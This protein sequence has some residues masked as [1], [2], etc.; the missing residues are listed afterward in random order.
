MRSYT[1]RERQR[2]G[3]TVE[4][5]G[6]AGCRGLGLL[7]HRAHHLDNVP[8]RVLPADLIIAFSAGENLTHPTLAG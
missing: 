5:S 4:N 1:A 8:E 7:G 2:L 6:L 3:S